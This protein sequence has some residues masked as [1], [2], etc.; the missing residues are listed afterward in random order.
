M[1]IYY[2]LFRSCFLALPVIYHEYLHYGG[3]EGDASHG[4]ENEA[5]VL[6]RELI[7]A[8]GLIA[9]AAPDNE[10]DLA[11]FDRSV[12]QAFQREQLEGLLFQVMVPLKDDA[13]VQRI[14]NTVIATYGEQLSEDQ[15]RA[16]ACSNILRENVRIRFFNATQDWC[17]Q[18]RWPRLDT[19]E[20]TAATQQYRQI[21]IRWLTRNNCIGLQQH[22]AILGDIRNTEWLAAWRNYAGRSASRGYLTVAYKD[23]LRRAEPTLADSPL[24][25]LD[26][27]LREHGLGQQSPE[28][29]PLDPELVEK[30]A[31]L[32]K[33]KTRLDELRRITG[34]GPP[35]ATG[36]SGPTT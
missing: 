31:E 32:E 13:A 12:L 33:L 9:G 14:N 19:A 20:T 7:F 26:R 28:P 30:L 10:E 2:R 11:A 35:G 15:A 5:E 6:L 27:A 24:A 23:W 3:P 4:I 36:N 18:V 22:A 8:R 25:V 29:T 16:K 21:V 34:G 17:P 1:G